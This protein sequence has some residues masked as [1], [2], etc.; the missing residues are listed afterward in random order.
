M[1]VDYYSDFSSRMKYWYS[2]G[3]KAPE[4]ISFTQLL[5]WN[6][7]EEYET[8]IRYAYNIG[9][10][11]IDYNALYGLEVM[12][13]I[14]EVS[15]IEGYYD[16]IDYLSFSMRVVCGILFTDKASGEQIT[17]KVCVEGFHEFDDYTARYK[18]KNRSNYFMRITA[19]DDSIK[20]RSRNQLDEY[21]VPV[22]GKRDF[23]KYAYN[24]LE[25]YCPEALE[26]D[27]KIEPEKLVERIGF[28]LRFE[29][30]S[31]NGSVSGTTVFR[32]KW[33]STYCGKKVVKK[34]IPHN[35]V[36]FSKNFD[37]EKRS[38]ILHECVHILSHN[39]FYELQYY[40]R[41]LVN[42]YSEGRNINFVP[43]KECKGLK[44]AETQANVIPSH[45]SMYYER[46]LEFIESFRDKQDRSVYNTDHTGIRS[47][48]DDIRLTYGVSRSS[49]KKRMVELGY[50]QAR[51]VYEWG[52]TGYVE[53]YDVPEN[54]P[55]DYTY[56]LSLYEMSKILGKSMLFDKYVYSGAFIYADGHLVL[57]LPKYVVKRF[58]KYYLTGYAKANMSE[59]CIPFRRIYSERSYNYTVGELKKDETEFFCQ[60]ELESETRKKL[61]KAREEWLLQ[62]YYIENDGK[63][64]SVG[65]TI[66]YHMTR[67][68]IT[69]EQLSERTGLGVRTIIGLRGNTCHTPKLE[70]LLAVVVGMGLEDMFCSDL[71]EKANLIHMTKGETYQLYRLMVSV[72]P[73]ISVYQ[74][75][76]YLVHIGKKPWTKDDSKGE[77]SST[78]I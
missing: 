14:T 43:D 9:S 51:G 12:P 76:D 73:D 47:L 28:N 64:M 77:T 39:L 45:I 8:F 31:E 36:L 75:N 20:M 2:G 44:W 10:L 24:F 55:D 35:T 52:D 66:R 11:P 6:Y 53:D 70:T 13:K 15:I 30:L 34:H 41:E 60:Y 25:M 21:L 19:Y 61:D 7:T 46:V 22:M 3:D 72:K 27:I 38:I 32:D 57:N 29:V 40:Y 1:N 54:F 69:V 78:A 16:R 50:K 17:Q 42:G 65:E 59:C 37:V 56:T 18:G 74:I 67:L 33:V 58:D 68:D 5:K 71:L 62:K 26:K 48:I 63:N 49:A 4:I 23:D